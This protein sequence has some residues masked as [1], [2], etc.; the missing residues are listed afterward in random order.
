MP[1]NWTVNITIQLNTNSLNPIFFWCSMYLCVLTTPPLPFTEK[2]YF[3]FGWITQLFVSKWILPKV[4]WKLVKSQQAEKLKSR[5]MQEGWMKNDQGWRMNDEGWMMKDDD[6]KLLRGF[7][8][9][10]TDGQ[11]NERTDICECRVA[12]ATEN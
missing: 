4:S 10:L 7:C 2:F 5:K 12:F 3:R 6:F 1:S 11:T 8:D 9:W